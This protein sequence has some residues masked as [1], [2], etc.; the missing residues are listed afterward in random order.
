[1]SML[2]DETDVSTFGEQL[3]VRPVD[4][5]VYWGATAAQQDVKT[6]TMS[7]DFFF[8]AQKSPEPLG[9]FRL[10]ML[11]IDSSVTNWYTY[12]YP[13]YTQQLLWEVVTSVEIRN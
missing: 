10:A 13:Q 3:A 2:K 7:A 9:D 1:M 8:K 4:I 11:A 12:Y 5:I 6:R